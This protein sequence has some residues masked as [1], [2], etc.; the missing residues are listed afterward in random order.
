MTTRDEWQA[1]VGKTW[2]ENYRLTD[3]AFAG[4]TQRLL[5]RISEH[6]GHA[7][8]DIGCGAGELS[9]AIARD[10]GGAQ[11]VGVDVSADLVAVAARRGESHGN[12]SFV[13][14]DA[15][16]WRD[17]GFAPDLLVSRHGVMFFDDPLA[18][19]GHLR[20]I[21]VPGAQ[22][23]F[24]CFRSQAENPWAADVARMVGQAPGDPDAP[25]PFA[26]ANPQRVERVLGDAGWHGIEF[27]PVDFAYVAG[28]GEDP[29]ADARAFFARIGPAARALRLLEGEA[30]DRF[31]TRLEQWLEK[32]RAGN[33]VAFAAA[34]WIV[35]ARRD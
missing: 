22:L 28:H 16:V 15:A 35:T 21:T 24:S 6:P 17:P 1:Q 10:R 29:V 34:A 14:G 19:F 23:V 20:D 8:L 7:V 11:V 12:A 31:A 9:L 27:E 4:L 32:H 26:F 18:A 2:A 33:L 30:R 3:R 13:E 25:G 5:E